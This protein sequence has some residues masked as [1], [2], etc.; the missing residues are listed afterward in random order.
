M[1]YVGALCCGCLCIP[2]RDAA[3]LFSGGYPDLDCA[4]PLKRRRDPP[5][6]FDLYSDASEAHGLTPDD[7]VYNQTISIITQVL[8]SIMQDHSM[9]QSCMLSYMLRNPLRSSCMM[10]YKTD[11]SQKPFHS[12][13]AL[14]SQA[15]TVNTKASTAALKVLQLSKFHFSSIDLSEYLEDSFNGLLHSAQLVSNSI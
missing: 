9:Y 3:L 15:L 8:Y 12:S 2:C 11:L 14:H 6:L 4:S 7:P 10:E 5:L 13:F 1:I